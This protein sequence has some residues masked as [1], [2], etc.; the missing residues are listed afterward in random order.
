MTRWLDW[1]ENSRALYSMPAQSALGQIGCLPGRTIAFRRVILQRVMHRFMTERF[2]GVFLEISDDRTLTNL[3]LKEGFRTVYQYTSLVYTDAPLRLDKLYRQQ[4]RWA[5]GSQYNTLRMLPWMIGHTPMLALF[6]TLDIVLPFLLAGVIAGWIYRWATGQGYNFYVA[7]LN[8]HGMANG[9]AVVLAL[10][11]VSSVLSM[12]I[13]QMR[14]LSERPTDFFRLP[15]FI[16][17]STAFL[18]PVR[19]IGFFR[20]AHVSGWGTRDGAYAGAW[21]RRADARAQAPARSSVTGPRLASTT[22]M[23]ALPAIG[24]LESAQHGGGRPRINPLAGVP[25]LIGAA[26]F[27][28]EVYFIATF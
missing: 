18:M 28:L 8:E 6:F 4:L 12:A 15:I 24:R 3:T 26:I 13:R 27:A 23:E 14:H 21:T 22:L 9:V 19:L 20:M 25:Y 7:F 16:I 10:M 2:L 17:V 1:L 11:V 5:R